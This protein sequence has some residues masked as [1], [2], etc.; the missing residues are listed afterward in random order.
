MTVLHVMLD[1][2]IDV[3]FTVLVMQSV[4]TIGSKSVE[5][6]VRG[7]NVHSC[8][9]TASLVDTELATSSIY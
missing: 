7:F 1:P 6:P 3:G 5:V 9:F 8:L 4:L 2:T